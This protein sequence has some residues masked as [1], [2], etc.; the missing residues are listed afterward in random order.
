MLVHVLHHGHCFDGA[1]SAALFCAFFRRTQDASAR[2]VFIPKAHAPGDPFEPADF[3]ADAVACVDF[4]YS[5]DPR[6][7]WWFDHHRSAFQLPG[8]REH[9]EADKSGR[10]FYDPE[11]PS[12]TGLIARVTA[13][14]FGFDPGPHA[15]LVRWAELIDAAAFED[16]SVA[17][18]LE[19]P[20]L[21]LM[22]FAEHNDDRRLLPRFIE[23][24]LARPFEAIARAE[25][26]RQ[27][28]EPVLE[29]HRLDI[30]LI[31]RRARV[32][33]GVLELDLLD[34]PGRAYNKFIAYH[35]HPRV[36]YV[37]GASIG[38]DGDARLTVGYN[39]WLPPEQ[40]EHDVAALCEHFGGGGHPFVGGVSFGPGQQAQ[41]RRAQASIAATLRGQSAPDEG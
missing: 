15:E 12:C 10:K 8:Q 2:F 27:I 3:R 14:R 34:Q 29:R 21:Q 5:S 37:V 22:T 19:R 33:D 23:D 25:Y 1:A 26:V 30:E 16:P 39:P 41:A 36:R 9:F 13:E 35:H 31:G 18:G 7:G 17:V 6:L 24:L 38:P 28:I 32:H 40:R 11:A 20:A 4:R